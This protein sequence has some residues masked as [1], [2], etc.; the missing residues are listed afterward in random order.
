MGTE[1]HPISTSSPLPLQVLRSA[2]GPLTLVWEGLVA[3]AVPL[4]PSCWLA[5]VQTP[6]VGSH[7]S[8]PF[9]PFLLLSPSPPSPG[10]SSPELQ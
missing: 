8:D 6:Q 1:L 2:Q 5:R 9:L 7:H 10:A 3:W 4:T